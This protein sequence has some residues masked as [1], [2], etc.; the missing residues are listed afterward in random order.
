MGSFKRAN[1][2]PKLSLQ[3]FDIPELLS[4]QPVKAAFFAI[5]EVT[6][7]LKYILLY[8]NNE[9]KTLLF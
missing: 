8:F 9:K 2:V 5:Y 3:S 4:I 7:L 1:E 6:L